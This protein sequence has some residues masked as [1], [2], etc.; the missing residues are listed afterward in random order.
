MQIIIRKMEPHEADTVKKVGKKAFAGGIE[1]V[2]V[3]KSKE[4]MVAVVDDKIVG[5]VIVK[6]ISTKNKKIGYIE[7]TF[8]HPDYHNKGIGKL[9]YKG[10]DTYLWAQGCDALTAGVKDDNVGSWKLFLDNGY[11]QVSLVETS[12]QLGFLTTL[13]LSFSTLFFIANGMEMYLNVKNQEVASKK[14]H[15]PLQIVLF[16]CV[17]L[18]LFM[19]VLVRKPSDLLAYIGAY[20]FVLAS[21]V[22]VGWVG[23]LFSKRQWYFRLNSG[24]AVI[25]AFISM[26][27]SIYPMI[28]RWY[29]KVYENTKAFRK[30]MGLV[31]LFQWIF[32]L[33][34]AAASH[35]L[36][37]EDNP[38]MLS[39]SVFAHILLF[40]HVLA[41][42]PFEIYGG[43]RIY[44]WNKVLFIVLSVFSIALY[45][46]GI[47][48]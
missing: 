10:A 43:R 22:I 36:N 41:F 1:K 11:S 38:F 4:A 26:T 13:K 7:M 9:L 39:V 32:L 27:G 31:S 16:L 18:L 12:R 37:L 29:P 47:F 33:C 17:N 15:S 23:T 3:S 6:Y 46:L 40:F 20:I 2:F 19:T 30:D 5:G 14:P 44:V 34:L 48:F 45:G 35:I 21:S 28:G 24:G 42:Y 8:I 25:V